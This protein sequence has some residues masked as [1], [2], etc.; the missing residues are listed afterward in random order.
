MTGFNKPYFYYINGIIFLYWH[1]YK[2]SNA[3]QSGSYLNFNKAQ[4]PQTYKSALIFCK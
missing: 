1:M 4:E 3:L 2:V